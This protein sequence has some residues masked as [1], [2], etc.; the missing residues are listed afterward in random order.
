MKSAEMIVTWSLDV[1]CPYCHADMDL[2]D[3]DND[4]CFS[5][6]IFNNQWDDVV[7]MEAHCPDCSKDFTISKVEC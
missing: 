7:G 1:E 5:T 4:G 3:Q 2:S 6:P